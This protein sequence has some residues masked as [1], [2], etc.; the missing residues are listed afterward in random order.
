MYLIHEKEL[1]RAFECLKANLDNDSS[2]KIVLINGTFGSGKS[3]FLKSL[4][5]ALLEENHADYI[6]KADYDNNAKFTID[7]LQNLAQNSF[8]VESDQLPAFSNNESSFINEQFAS[9][10][11]TLRNKDT[12][13]FEKIYEREYLKDNYHYHLSSLDEIEDLSDE[14]V[15]SSIEAIYP[16][17]EKYKTF[18]SNP[19]R[20]ALE[21]L[22]VDLMTVLFSGKTEFPIPEKKYKI[23]LVLDGFDKQSWTVQNWI[24]DNLIPAV[25]NLRFGDFVSYDTQFIDPNI[26][27][28]E[29]FDFRYIFSFRENVLHGRLSDKW[30]KLEEDFENISLKPASDLVMHSFFKSEGIEEDDFKDL[31]KNTYG[32][33]YIFNLKV[34]YK[35][36]GDNEVD[37]ISLVYHLAGQKILD[38]FE[39]QQADWIRCT[40]FLDEFDARGLEFFP[41]IGEKSEKAFT[42]MSHLSDMFVHENG[43]LKLKQDLKDLLLKATMFDSP[44]SSKGYKKIA[45]QYYELAPVINQFE[46]H[47]FNILCELAYFNW[48]DTE[49]ILKKVFPDRIEEL[50]EFIDKKQDLFEFDTGM[51]RINEELGCKLDRLNKI[52]DADLYSNKMKYIK[53]IQAEYQKDLQDSVTL[54]GNKKKDSSEKLSHTREELDLILEEQQNSTKSK[55]TN[56]YKKQQK[57]RV[58][59]NSKYAKYIAF[60]ALLAVLGIKPELLLG[61]VFDSESTFDIAS[62]MFYILSLLMVA[63]I[64]IDFYSSRSKVKA[65]PA[66]AANIPA[67]LMTEDDKKIKEL[68]H[69]EDYLKNQLAGLDE[70]IRIISNK[71]GKYVV[72]HCEK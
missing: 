5:P 38:D 55:R 35:K 56:P 53:E 45:E 11:S 52:L 51:L 3:F 21:S 27:I 34:E 24:L 43:K 42:F 66:K 36:V 44:G 70:E 62:K 57:F 6:F 72:R 58:E 18:F 17:Q 65:K 46:E 23:V 59:S 10:L 54:L 7:I 71:L 20:V 13:L 49:F 31:A 2:K 19:T 64:G 8:Y 40:A 16:G 61:M 63:Y 15:C 69:R 28:N 37:N 39:E 60:A 67:E 4:L 1:F 48:F 32:I 14:A 41:I 29:F 22:I 26:K 33:P 47:D 12:S 30:I 68:R 25:D 50:S 9:T